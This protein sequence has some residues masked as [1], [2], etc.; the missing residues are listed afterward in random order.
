MVTRKI[1]EKF[2]IYLLV[3][4]SLRIYVFKYLDK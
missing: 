3:F 2:F 4:V 1:W